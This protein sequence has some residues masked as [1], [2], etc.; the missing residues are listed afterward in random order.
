MDPVLYYGIYGE[1]VDKQTILRYIGYVKF[2]YLYNLIKNYVWR[3][4]LKVK[5]W[6]EASIIKIN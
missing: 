2:C 1:G 4:W 3:A 5:N 6:R